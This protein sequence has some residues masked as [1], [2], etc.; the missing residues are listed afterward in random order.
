[1]GLRGVDVT[2][3]ASFV[4]RRL[5]SAFLGVA[6]LCCFDR[7]VSEPA[8]RRAIALALIAMLVTVA[9]FGIIELARGFTAPGLLPPL[10]W[11]CCLL[12]CFTV[13]WPAQCPGRK[14]LKN[15]KRWACI[16]PFDR[17]NTPARTGGRV[18]E[19]ARLESV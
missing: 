18:V 7:G 6:A 9:G 2:P 8:A 1:M 17:A 12:L 13:F 16:P 3:E 19:G 15:F 5:V 4:G 11:D 10:R 14:N